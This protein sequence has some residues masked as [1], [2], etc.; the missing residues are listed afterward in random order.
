MYI[1]V[2]LPTTTLQQEHTIKLKLL[3]TT[4]RTHTIKLK[5]N[6]SVIGIALQ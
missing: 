1:C 3:L 5:G 4:S 6:Q 2:L